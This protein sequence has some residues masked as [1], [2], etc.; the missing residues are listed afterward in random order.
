MINAFGIPGEVNAESMIFCAPPPPDQGGYAHPL[1]TPDE[2]VVAA[3]GG[4]LGV[5]RF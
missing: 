3:R 4:Y 1:T 5:C 2:G